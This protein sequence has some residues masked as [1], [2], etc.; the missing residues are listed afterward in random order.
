[1]QQNKGLPFP[2]ADPSIFYGLYSYVKYHVIYFLRIIST[3][4][5]SFIDNIFEKIFHFLVNFFITAAIPFYTASILPFPR[6]RGHDCDLS[7]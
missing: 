5:L 3:F 1:M 7:E 6:I 4:M 2:I